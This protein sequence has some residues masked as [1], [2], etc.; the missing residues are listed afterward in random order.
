M[1][2]RHCLNRKFPQDLRITEEY[3]CMIL[4]NLV[5]GWFY[6]AEMFA[7]ASLNNRT[8]TLLNCFPFSIKTEF[9]VDMCRSLGFSLILCYYSRYSKPRRVPCDRVHC[10]EDFSADLECQRYFRKY[11]VRLE[12]GSEATY[13]TDLLNHAQD[14]VANYSEEVLRRFARYRR[15]RSYRQLHKIRM[16]ADRVAA[17]GLRGA[18]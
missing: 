15:T 12:D 13:Q 18:D 14:Q 16:A 6:E 3:S 9:F 8:E 10:I 5:C 17:I 2:G 4:L 7:E 1:C 11:L